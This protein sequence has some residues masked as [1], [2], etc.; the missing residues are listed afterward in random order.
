MEDKNASSKMSHEIRNLEVDLVTN[1]A[2]QLCLPHTD[3]H[4]H[5]ELLHEAHE[6][7]PYTRQLWI[8]L[9]QINE[10]VYDCFSNDKHIPDEKMRPVK[11]TS[12][13]W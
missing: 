9:L 8:L 12:E 10:R 3:C 2:A 1:L 6:C 11:R 13:K 7:H 5:F 4:Y